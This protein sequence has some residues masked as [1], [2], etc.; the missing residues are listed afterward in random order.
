MV[1]LFRSLAHLYVSFFT[2]LSCLLVRVREGEGIAHLP[3]RCAPNLNVN[4]LNPRVEQT[5]PCNLAKMES[6]ETREAPHQNPRECR[7]EENPQEN[8]NQ[9]FPLEFDRETREP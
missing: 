1:F 4:T 2:M 8:T 3:S 5:L 9:A 6:S 7:E